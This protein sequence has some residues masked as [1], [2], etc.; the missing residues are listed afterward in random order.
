[1]NISKYFIYDLYYSNQTNYHEMFLIK[2]KKIKINMTIIQTII[3]K[4]DVKSK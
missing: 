3:Q 1:M 2:Y 4:L